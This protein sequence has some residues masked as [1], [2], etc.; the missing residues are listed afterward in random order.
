MRAR[1]I[2]YSGLLE[3]LPQKRVGIEIDWFLDIETRLERERGREFDS[4]ERERERERE[5]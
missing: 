4:E 3:R 2:L 5:R 1:D